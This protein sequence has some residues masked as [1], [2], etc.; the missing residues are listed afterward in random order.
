MLERSQ[1]S[2]IG[3]LL[4][5]H[6][7]RFKWNTL[8]GVVLKPVCMTLNGDGSMSKWQSLKG[9]TPVKNHDG[10]NSD[11][12]PVNSPLGNFSLLTH[13]SIFHVKRGNLEPLNNSRPQKRKIPN[14][15]LAKTLVSLHL[16]PYGSKE[17]HRELMQKH[18]LLVPA[19]HWNCSMRAFGIFWFWGHKLCAFRLATDLWLIT[20]VFLSAI[21][22]SYGNSTY[23]VYE[24]HLLFSNICTVCEGHGW[25]TRLPGYVS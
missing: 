21:L 24:I 5:G 19:K 7:N 9:Y 6:V 4:P 1:L 10:D 14:A 22:M 16:S 18:H 3:C 13:F 20:N 2:L 23:I 25:I 17:M 15:Q 12:Y 8:Y 11:L